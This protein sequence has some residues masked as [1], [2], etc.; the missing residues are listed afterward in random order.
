[1]D[2]RELPKSKFRKLLILS[3]RKFR[4]KIKWNFKSA[5]W[6]LGLS[7][8]SHIKLA[9]LRANISRARSARTARKATYSMMA[10]VSTRG[11][12]VVCNT[13]EICILEWPWSPK[14]RSALPSASPGF[15][16]AT[17]STSTRNAAAIPISKRSFA[18]VSS[19]FFVHNR[20]A[21]LR[22]GDVCL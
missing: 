11:S 10:E 14:P 8:S 6:H 5:I 2:A 16:S 9:R 15:S 22:R 17:A 7:P 4:T 18:N 12:W 20:H 19:D 1:M 13:S 21:W 3:G